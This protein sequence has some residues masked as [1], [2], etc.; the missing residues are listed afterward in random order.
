MAAVSHVAQN[1][2]TDELASTK[3]PPLHHVSQGAVHVSMQFRGMPRCNMCSVRVSHGVSFHATIRHGVVL[4]HSMSTLVCHITLASLTMLTNFREIL[5]SW[6]LDANQSALVDMCVV[7]VSYV[8]YTPSPRS[9]EGHAGG[10]KTVLFHPFS[11]FPCHITLSVHYISTP[12][13]H[14]YIQAVNRPR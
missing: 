4:Y 6:I 3:S 5:Y 8:V 10:Y 12:V 1:T 2:A 11:V 14:S 7:F 13:L 9:H